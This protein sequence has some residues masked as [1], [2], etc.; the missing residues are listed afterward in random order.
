MWPKEFKFFHEF[1]IDLKSIFIFNTVDSY[2][3]GMTYYDLKQYGNIP[4][5]KIYRMIKKLEEQ[6]YLTRRNGIS[7]DTGRPK[8]LYFLSEEGKIRLQEL[9]GRLGEILKFIKLRFPDNLED[10][11]H[12]KLLNA[13]YAVWSSPVEFIFQLDIEEEKK[14]KLLSDMEADLKDLLKKIGVAK[15]KIERVILKSNKEVKTG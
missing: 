13:T 7:N 9:K 3:N 2:P 1:M 4:H 5:S 6:G 15:Q 14:L 11:N 10:F 12:E 8:H